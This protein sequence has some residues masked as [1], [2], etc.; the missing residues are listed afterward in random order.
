MIIVNDRRK[1]TIELYRKQRYLRNLSM[2]KSS[3]EQQKK[4]RKK[5]D[6]LYKKF[7]FYDG[8]NKALDKDKQKND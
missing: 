6:D 1:K 8:L 2:A 3:F 5:Q 7:K 4:I